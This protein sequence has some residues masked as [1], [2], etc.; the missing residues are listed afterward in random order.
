[1]NV[2]RVMVQRFLAEQ[3]PLVWVLLASLGLHIAA[4]MV[5]SVRSFVTPMTPP[6][7]TTVQ[8]V[9]TADETVLGLA[10]L[11]DPSLAALGSQH[12]FSAAALMPSGEFPYQPPSMDQPAR[13][14][15]PPRQT[16][17]GPRAGSLPVPR[18]TIVAK[19]APPTSDVAEPP[20][21]PPATRVLLSGPLAARA[22]A[23][24]GAALRA[25]DGTPQQAT[26]LRV[27]VDGGGAVRYALVM[28][29]CGSAA[30]D[31]RAIQE[32]SRWRFAEVKGSADKLDWGEV[33]IVW[34]ADQ[35]AAPTATGVL[36]A[37]PPRLTPVAPTG[38]VPP[39]TM[40][41]P[42]P[43]LRTEP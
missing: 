6:S 40:M 9:G 26:V 28:E 39:P 10:A 2:A 24:A 31:R 33:R 37:N 17:L 27:A 41:P 30:A 7:Q 42:S 43:Q 20:I 4:G 36:R 8:Y 23:G 18:E 11:R 21:G 14:L 32:V 3:R 5:F 38:P 12:G 15:P 13:P 16:D 1:M 22:P 19:L 34:G 29:S 25:E 35:R